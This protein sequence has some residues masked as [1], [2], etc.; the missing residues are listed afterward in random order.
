MPHV[1]NPAEGFI[2]TANQQVQAV[3][4][5]PYLTQDWSYGYRSQRIR[6]L[7]TGRTGLTAADMS[8]IQFDNRNG[9]APDA[10]AAAAGRRTSRTTR[11]PARRSSCCKGWD[12]TQPPD[13][14]AAAYYNAVWRNLMR[15]GFDDELGDDLQADG[16]DRWFQ[17]VTTL[18]KRKSRPVVGQQGDARRDRE[19]RR[20]RPPGDGR[21][22][23]SS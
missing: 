16:G 15:L 13:S 7:L 14:A 22:R 23:G 17:V 8:A 20:D 12:F 1:L 3:R 18:L 5:S 6:D 4:R 21:R 2:V 9:M 19:P 10:G 11:S